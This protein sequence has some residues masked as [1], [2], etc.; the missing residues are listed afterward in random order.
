MPDGV[1]KTPSANSLE[2]DTLVF[3]S[4]GALVAEI[5][6][7]SLRRVDRQV[8]AKHQEEPLRDWLYELNW[9]VAPMQQEAGLGQPASIA[10]PL[11]IAEALRV[12]AAQHSKDSAMAEFA[13]LF[14]QLETLS[15]QYVCRALRQLGWSLSPHERFT[16]EAKAADLRIPEKYRRLFARMLEMLATDGILKRG[17]EGWVV[18][19]LPPAQGDEISSDDL[20]QRYAD[21][22]SELKMTIRCGEHLAEAIRGDCDPLDLLFPDG[23]TKDI[24]KLYSD[25]PFARFYQGLVS[26][27][28]QELL[29]RFPADRPLRILEIGG[30]T[31]STTA[32]V[33]PELPSVRTEYVFTD[34]S[35]LFFA[36]WMA[37]ERPCTRPA[38]QIWLTI[39]VSWPAPAG[40][41]RLHI[42]A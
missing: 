1:G 21:C 2:V 29:A 8:L 34:A 36:K 9:K 35:P 5:R 15:T 4:T 40:P 12:Y 38:M 19:Q 25:S 23:S 13:S 28:V 39:L 7:L 41:S 27:A 14:P 42:R 26:T 30:G 11:E 3:D 31:G 6:G 16:T 24:E 33:L 17:D 22:S 18:C 32:A 20:L 37:S 10:S